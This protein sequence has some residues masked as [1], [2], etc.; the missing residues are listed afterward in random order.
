[1]VPPMLLSTRLDVAAAPICNGQF[2]LVP[3]TNPGNGNNV[4]SS[5]AAITASDA[6]A[7]GYDVV[8]TSVQGQLV[9]SVTNALIEHWDGSAWSTVNG[10]NLSSTP[11]LTTSYAG[12]LNSV[13]GSG[14]NDVWAVGDAGLIEHWNGT[15]WSVVASAGVSAN[16]RGVWADSANDAWIVGN[17]GA[18]QQGFEE[19]WNGTAWTAVAGADAATTGWSSVS[20]S[21]A[22]D[23]WAFGASGGGANSLAAEHWDGTAWTSIPPNS[24]AIANSHGTPGAIADTG[25][26]GTF[27]GDYATPINGNS[28]VDRDFQKWNGAAWVVIG[29]ITASGPPDYV[30]NSAAASAAN[31]LWFA[32]SVGAASQTSN[33]VELPPEPFVEHYDGSQFTEV[34]SVSP[35]TNSPPNGSSVPDGQYNGVAAL[36]GHAWAVGYSVDTSTGNYDTLIETECPDRSAIVPETPAVPLL[37]VGFVGGTAVLAKR[38]RTNAS[39]KG[40]TP[41]PHPL[42]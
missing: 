13:A 16:L 21:G 2:Q 40:T 38:P 42:T 1:M 12:R 34:S 33:G 19:H 14:P 28:P 32:G 25:S 5:V 36:P 7:V 6:W 11:L 3:S 22:H 8:Q 27:V 24:N 26:S 9:S 10:A 23:V 30:L 15:G 37:L 39:L 41:A 20:G 18:S 29:R 17:S 35:N 31:D 4:L